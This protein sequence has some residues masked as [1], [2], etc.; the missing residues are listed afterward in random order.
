MAG[1]HAAALTVA[2]TLLARA[3]PS[4]TTLTRASLR[5]SPNGYASVLRQG[6]TGLR[7]LEP[8]W[9]HVLVA[10][11][12]CV[13]RAPW[14]RQITLSAPPG[15]LSPEPLRRLVGEMAVASSNVRAVV[16][17]GVHT[18]AGRESLLRQLPV[19]VLSAILD[20]VAPKAA[21]ALVLQLPD[22]L[23]LDGSDSSDSSSDD[24][25]DRDSSSSSGDDD[26]G[27]SGN[28]DEES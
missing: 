4:Q 28:V 14:L 2:L 9:A 25:D 22:S 13:A 19:E 17:G 24:S 12:G 10:L 6:G 11:R 20:I 18:R 23:D 16:L 3:L 7:G 5:V 1:P 15:L 21:C 26:D 27:S 8:L